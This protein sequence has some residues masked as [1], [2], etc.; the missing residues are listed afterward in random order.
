MASYRINYHVFYVILLILSLDTFKASEDPIEENLNP[1]INECG[2]AISRT[3]P[4]RD[5]IN[6]ALACMKNGFK[7]V[8]WGY[9]EDLENEFIAPELRNFYSTVNKLTIPVGYL[10]YTHEGAR[11]ALLIRK[12]FLERNLPFMTN[13]P[14]LLG[15]LLGYTEDDILFFYQRWAYLLTFDHIP[16]EEWIFDPL[17]K[18]PQKKQNTFHAFVEKNKTWKIEY[19]KEKSMAASWLKANE[20]YSIEYLSNFDNF[21]A[22]IQ[23]AIARVVNYFLY[24]FVP[25]KK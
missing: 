2:A 9:G 22:P 21:F 10:L 13:N 15:T 11:N 4:R 8:Y 7:S 16:D 18:W 6:Q 20:H 14:Y 17:S 25:H 23:S 5:T 1:S 3:H 19:D 12:Y 24:L